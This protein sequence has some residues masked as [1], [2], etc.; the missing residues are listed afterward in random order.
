MDQ[1]IIADK[2]SYDDFEASVAFREIK[3]PKK[4]SIKET[5]PFSNVTYDFSA[6]NGE[7]YWEERELKYTFE[8]TADDPEQLEEKK[9]RF[10]AW[11]TAVMA[12]DIHD[13]F[14]PGYHFKGSY[15]DM[16]VDDDEGLDKT[17]LTVTFKAYPYMVAD[18][19]C[20]FESDPYSVEKNHFAMMN[21]SAHRI[22][23]TA[24]ATAPIFMKHPDFDFKYE[25]N[26]TPQSIELPIG[27]ASW[28]LS[29]VDASSTGSV[30]TVTFH[31][32][33]F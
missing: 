31:E 21:D 1:L 8:I 5:V 18:M 28:E 25:I 4:K 10:A 29:A 15:E 12:Q 19:P 26:T 27:A 17:T 20:V 6:I 7:V 30:I 11:V 13:P 9:S 16:D 33:V 3:M 23:A 24:T 14:I 32:E 2:A 22:Y